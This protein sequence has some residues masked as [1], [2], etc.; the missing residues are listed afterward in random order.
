MAMQD[1]CD[2]VAGDSNGDFDICS[3]VG[4]IRKNSSMA[5]CPM[6]E[7]DSRKL[8]H[9]GSLIRTLGAAYA[10]LTVQEKMNAAI[11]LQNQW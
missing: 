10:P 5:I 6:E 7:S 8:E 11:F 1:D 3:P 9:D 2:E 4:D